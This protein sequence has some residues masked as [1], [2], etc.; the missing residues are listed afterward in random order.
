M[1]FELKGLFQTGTE[2]S[3]NQKLSNSFPEPVFKLSSY[4]IP[5]GFEIRFEARVSGVMCNVQ[6][7]F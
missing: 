1:T 3:K 2:D 7:N 6:D 4:S 5:N